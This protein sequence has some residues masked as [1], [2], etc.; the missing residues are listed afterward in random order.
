MTA[1]FIGVV[2]HPASSFAVSTGP[3]GLGR[4]LASGLTKRGVQTSVE[5]NTKNAYQPSM[6]ALDGPAVARSLT[7]QLRVERHWQ[8]FLRDNLNLGQLMRASAARTQRRLGEW[9]RFLRPWHGKNKDSAG[10]RRIRRLINIELSHFALM[11]ASV[12]SGSE[13][14]LIL[15]DDASATD[16]DDCVNG[17]VGLMN[18]GPRQPAYVNVSQSFSAQDLSIS[19]LLS[20]VPGVQWEGTQERQLLAS[21]KPV[22]NTVCAILYRTSFV[23]ELLEVTDAF[24]VDPV[25]PIDWKLNVAL[26]VLF[27]QGS[28]EAGDCWTVV[29]GPI[30]QLSMIPQR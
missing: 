5:V 16:L 15:E 1:L 13:W 17:L 6:L 25:I 29:P 19:H 28:L 20:P 27:E 11:R 30:D 22:T 21:S 9:F 18:Q 10:A 7:A 4:S 12:A 8:A 2:S 14:T 23:K 3:K 26:M 24:P